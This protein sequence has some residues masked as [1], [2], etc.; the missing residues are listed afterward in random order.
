F[1]RSASDGLAVNIHESATDWIAGGGEG[2][3]GQRVG[4]IGRQ[5]FARKF[6]GRLNLITQNFRR[7]QG[8]AVARCGDDEPI[9]R[10]LEEPL[11]RF[12]GFIGRQTERKFTGSIR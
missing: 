12:G 6:E 3:D 5:W 9:L 7:C 2:N 4:S 8:K 11:F 10:L 1:D